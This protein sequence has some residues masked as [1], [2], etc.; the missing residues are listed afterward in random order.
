MST[1][2]VDFVRDDDKEEL[3]DAFVKWFQLNN[4]FNV[5]VGSGHKW[6]M[7]SMTFDDALVL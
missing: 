3:G 4:T 6:M 2:K 7:T 1:P 5:E